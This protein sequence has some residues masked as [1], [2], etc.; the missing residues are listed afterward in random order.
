D[1]KH[2]MHDHACPRHAALHDGSNG[3][4]AVADRCCFFRC[5]TDHEAGLIHEGEDG[6]VECVAHIDKAAKL[7]RGLCGHCACIEVTV[8]CDHADAR[9]IEPR[10]S[11][12]ERGAEALCHFEKAVPVHH[13]F[14]DLAHVEGFARVP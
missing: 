7:L 14:H 13:R 6:Q 2:L 1:A 3:G 5:R 12:D 10:K 9:A 11:G 4:C 8:I